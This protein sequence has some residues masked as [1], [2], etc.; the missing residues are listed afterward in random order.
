M[1]LKREKRGLSTIVATLIIIL[2]V[3]VS[4]AVIWIVVR[5]LILT[6][7]EK[8]SLDS[9][10]LNLDIK[11][12]QMS[13]DEVYV[14][15]KRNAGEGEFIGLYF[16]ME[17]DEESDVFSEYTT[18]MELEVKVFSFR[19]QNLTS[20]QIRFIK[21][22]PI[23]VT[24]SG[25]EFIGDAKDVYIITGAEIGENSTCVVSCNVS[26][27]LAL[28][29]TNINYESFIANWD[30]VPIASNYYLDVASDNDFANLVID[31]LDVGNVTNYQVI[32]LDNRE[33]YYYRVRAKDNTCTSWSSNVISV[34]LFIENGL[35][36]NWY[37]INDS[38]EL[39]PEGW[40]VPTYNEV[41]TLINF[42]G[43]INGGGKLK[44]TGLTHWD[45]TNTKAT[46]I[47][48]FSAYGSGY[49]GIVNPPLSYIFFNLNHT[50]KGWIYGN[51]SLYGNNYPCNFFGLSV[52]GDPNSI[53]AYL[54][55]GGDNYNQAFSVRCMRNTSVGWSSGELIEDIDNN[56]YETTQVGTQI[57]LKQN[58]AV[59]HYNNGDAIPEVTDYAGWAA[60]TTGALCAYNNNWAYV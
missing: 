52:Y 7:S 56:Y 3:L 30:A 24:K 23:F 16:V 19:L 43:Y 21:I 34:S 27:P 39:C 5:E 59:T 40:H 29:A 49:K 31:D 33:S 11:E 58:L 35:L 53:L 60:L 38:R 13:C 26:V 36:Y 1:W 25:E 57:W 54:E 42:V 18:M 15:V 2:L 51:V 9:I 32:G 47:Y 37:A 28:D 4:T 45:F 8:T 55:Y 50:F 44:E 22:Y 17:G 20:D 12:A 6:N 41:E 48:G 10:T 14:T 46:D